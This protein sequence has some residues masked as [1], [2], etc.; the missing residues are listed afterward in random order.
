MSSEIEALPVG[1]VAL[2]QMQAALARLYSEI[3]KLNASLVLFELL[4]ADRASQA[5]I[6]IKTAMNKISLSCSSESQI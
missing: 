5:V 6:E 1:G 4:N 2:E 3:E